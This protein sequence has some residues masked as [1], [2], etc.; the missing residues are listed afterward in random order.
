MIYKSFFSLSLM[1]SA[2]KCAAE[3]KTAKLKDAV[4]IKSKCLNSLYKWRKMHELIFAV[5][6][7][8]HSDS[9]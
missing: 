7:H 4:R 3:T 5:G 6:T 1:S 8:S 9:V 2:T